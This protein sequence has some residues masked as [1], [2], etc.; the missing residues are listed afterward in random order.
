MMIMINDEMD[1]HSFTLTELRAIYRT[2][3]HSYISY[4][5]VEANNV[6]RRIMRIVSKPMTIET[7]PNETITNEA[8][9]KQS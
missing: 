4:E 3:E 5:D 6:F 8:K 1:N 2:I 9:E 7:K